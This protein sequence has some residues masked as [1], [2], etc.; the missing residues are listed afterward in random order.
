MKRVTTLRAFDDGRDRWAIA[1]AMPEPA[2]IP[3]VERYSAWREHT[4]TFSTRR[5]LAATRGVFI[6]NIG[7]ALEIVDARGTLHRLDAGE[8]F[9]GGMAEATSLSRSTGE[10][11]GLHVHMPV[12]D[13]AAI[14]GVP[15]S[16]IANITVSLDA[17]AGDATRTLGGRLVE[18]KD[19]E[20]RFAM[21]DAFIGDRLAD[22]DPAEAT[23]RHALHHLRNGVSISAL[24]DDFGWSRKRLARWFRDSTGLLPREFARLARFE[25]FAEAIQRRSGESLA[26]LAY[27]TG[28]A[29][30][31]HLTHD[32]RKL[33]CM[34]PGEL[35]DRLIPAGGGVRD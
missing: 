4:Q 12:E 22:R 9:I 2:L 8:G 20:A 25:R 29:D 31:A 5:E 35:R 27:Q 3:H 21:L 17:L 32:V 28:Y 1:E 11:A 30:Q 10:M 23:L 34:T 33:S 7:A 14:F 26:D 15:L 6:I 24:A 18:A 16:A 13:L 19:S